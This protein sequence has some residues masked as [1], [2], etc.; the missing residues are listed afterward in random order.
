MTDEPSRA[1]RTPFGV[2]LVSLV[3][4]L[5]GVLWLLSWGLGGMT[6]SR[7]LAT[8]AL[9]IG[10]TA[11]LLASFL[12]RQHFVAWAITLAFVGASTLWRFVRVLGGR[13]DD[14]SNAIVGLVIVA[15]LLA[16]HERFRP[17]DR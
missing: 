14:L 11:L 15:Y 8:V 7:V 2:V 16:R 17:T 5:Y 4:V 6:G 12:Y 9:P 10:L 13:V 1:G 3:L